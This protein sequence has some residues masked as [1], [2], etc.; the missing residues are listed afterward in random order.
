MA[1]R[2]A[3]AFRE[4]VRPRA[5]LVFTVLAEDPAG[6]LPEALTAFGKRLNAVQYVSR[7]VP[8]PGGY[9]MLVDLEKASKRVLSAVP[10]WL[11]GAL[12]A[13][14]ITDATVEL[15]PMMGEQYYDVWAFAPAARAF[16][17]APV[18]W[19]PHDR[20]P[21]DL[22]DA[23]LAWLRDQ[24][25]PD[26]PPFA[27]TLGAQT[28]LTWQT[29]AAMGAGVLR[30]HQTT[31]VTMVTDFATSLAVAVVSNGLHGASPRASVS[32]AGAGWAPGAVAER[33][34]GQREMIRRYPH[35]LGWAAVT[36]EA[37]AAW[38]MSEDWVERPQDRASR[39]ES[40][41]LYELASDVL[42]P[43]AMWY[44]VLSAGHLER[45]GGPP[46]GAVPLRD[47]RYEL[48]VGEPE[49]WLPGHPDRYP[50][51]DR[52]RELL[53][54][55]LGTE[56]AARDVHRARLDRWRDEDPDGLLR[57]A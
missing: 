20:T 14:G 6:R 49:Q 53:A 30:A 36:A 7:P 24:P 57:D 9:L 55:C 5:M 13:A 54:G 27:L 31:S 38:T 3:P 2:V 45:L 51:R 48:T 8:V 15:P 28:A 22:L 32:A 34:R 25:G 56:E 39:E 21:V 17:V 29:A 33:M 18:A 10:D 23:V 43:D 42:V 41:R 47:G 16:L 40:R 1:V 35:P 12:T 46:P 44:Q 11:V 50:V 52:C 19:P 37:D 26:V 4:A